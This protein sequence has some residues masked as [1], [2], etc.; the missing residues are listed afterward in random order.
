[1]VLRTLINELPGDLIVPA[2]RLDLLAR[3]YLAAVIFIAQDT[4]RN[5]RYWDDHLLSY[6]FHDFIQSALAIVTLATEGM[7]NVAKREVRFLV[8]ASIKLCLVQ[9]KAYASTIA[10]K[11][12][13]FDKELASQ[14]ISIKQHLELTLLPK[15]LRDAFVDEA[16]RV[17]GLTSNY[18]H[19]TPSQIEERIA[20]VDAGRIGGKES[21]LDFGA[22]NSLVERG[23]AVSLTLLFHSVPKHVAGDWLVEPNGSTKAWVF[24]ESRFIA[25]ID[26]H[27]DY[28]H[29]RQENPNAIKETRNELIRF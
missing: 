7:L 9:Q 13:R 24:T 5:P 16:G 21:A 12:Q 6:L 14:R 25:A 29:E 11:L 15:E 18:V 3:S 19:L 26:S 4:A 27:F 10:E 17:Y 2:K 22:L 23:L 28:K 8:E 20:A 1:M